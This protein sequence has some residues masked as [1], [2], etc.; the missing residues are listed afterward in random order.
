[1]PT[2]K[3]N[4]APKHDA[5]LPDDLAA[6]LDALAV[7][8]IDAIDYLDKGAPSGSSFHFEKLHLLEQQVYDVLSGHGS[9]LSRYKVVRQMIAMN[10]HVMEM[11]ESSDA[12]LAE[13]HGFRL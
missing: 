10:S 11:L 6:A 8:V 12:S 7:A 13:I 4:A 1:M 5:P 9:R 2:P 3:H